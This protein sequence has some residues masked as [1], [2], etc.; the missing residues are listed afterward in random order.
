MSLREKYGPWAVITGG[1]EGVGAAFARKLA[2]AGIN[3]VLVARKP[4]PLAALKH[5]LRN[6][7]QV[8][9]LSADLIRPDA[10]DAIAKATKDI[11]IG[12]LICNAGA[13]HGM[14]RFL[15]GPASD[16]LNIARL[17]VEVPLSFCHHFGLSMR[18]RKRGGILLVSSMAGYVGG[19]G[20]ASYSGAK[21]FMRIFAEALWYELK[22]FSVD[23][24]CLV[25]GATR[26]PAME[27]AGMNVVPGVEPAEPDM[28]AQ[29]GLDRLA[30]GPVHCAN[31]GAEAAQM[32]A[33]APRAE[34]IA[35][36]D[37]VTQ[38]LFAKRSS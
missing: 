19:P 4:S 26:T 37:Q 21:A 33:S 29:E 5:E 3:L 14:H 8:R 28:V 25:L 38:A 22:P 12:L 13:E 20:I 9:T 15:D 27:R 32:M 1:S 34:L 35:Q 18:T 6:K 23:V 17:N 24:L 30:H 16:A 2:D 36:I 7:V 31:N 10:F 11:E